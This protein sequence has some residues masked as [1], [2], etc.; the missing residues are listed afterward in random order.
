MQNM[1]IPMLEQSSPPEEVRTLQRKGLSDAFGSSLVEMLAAHKDP[2][3]PP[4]RICGIANV[5]GP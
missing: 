5:I 2:Y 4:N 1:Q 3:N